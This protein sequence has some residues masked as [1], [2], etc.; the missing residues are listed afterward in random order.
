MEGSACLDRFRE[1]A[2][3]NFQYFF[4]QIIVQRKGRELKMFPEKS[5]CGRCSQI[6]QQLC[7]RA[8]FMIALIVIFALNYICYRSLLRAGQ[9]ASSSSGGTCQSPE[10]LEGDRFP[11]VTRGLGTRLVNS[12]IRG[13]QVSA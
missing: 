5:G 1:D 4:V 10:L 9:H 7:N 8:R 11:R 13:V 2:I 3:R 12:L 6:G